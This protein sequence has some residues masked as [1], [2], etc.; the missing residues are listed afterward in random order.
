MTET[1]DYFREDTI[2]ALSTPAG[3]GAIAVIRV[4]GS[5]A[6]PII[7]QLCP[8]LLDN[9]P[10]PRYA[11]LTRVVA[12][13]DIIDEVLVT[14]FPGPH[15]YTGEDV[16]EI[17]CH[18]GGAIVRAILDRLCHAGAR[19]A[20]P[21][22]FTFRAVRNGKL[23]LTQAQAVSDLITATT[24]RLRRAAFSSFTGAMAERL[25]VLES[26][27]VDIIVRL[28]ASIEFPDDVPEDQ[29]TVEIQ[30]IDRILESVRRIEQSALRH[31][32]LTDGLRFVLLGRPNVGKSCLFN[33]LIG[34]D[35]A[36]VS[37]HPGTTRDTIE[38]TIEV[39]G[40]P[41]TLVDTAGLH[42]R[43]GEVESLGIERTRQ[44]ASEADALLLVIEAADNPNETEYRLIDSPDRPALVIL[45]KIDLI[46]DSERLT[47]LSGI[48]VSALTGEGIEDL[49]RGL[50]KLIDSL[51][52][53]QKEE[54]QVLLSAFQE[55]QLRGACEALARA[56]ETLS[57][58]ESEIAVEEIR[59]AL[60]CLARLRG[61]DLAPD[62]IGEIFSR[63]CVGK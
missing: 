22:E 26:Q 42:D 27:F 53:Q 2:A 39:A 9:L 10:E 30:E 41:M 25:S 17:S 54:P 6:F 37:P 46:P 21:G 34:H 29:T 40:V 33:R 55:E 44:A 15:S 18:G 57:R 58:E 7:E 13:G 16:V 45:N 38:A 11:S 36:I 32:L 12:D 20:G 14:L 28:E 51:L 19:L 62:I 60:R 8:S 49:W 50:E 56:R 47:S 24:E 35:R 1:F 52:P 43:A 31:R 63:F 48:P 23:D 4:S 5:A 59:Y 61:A 3:G